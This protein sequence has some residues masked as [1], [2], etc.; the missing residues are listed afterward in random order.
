MWAESHQQRKLK[1][2]RP[3]SV[4]CTSP[5]YGLLEKENLAKEV[6]KLK[7]EKAKLLKQVSKQAN[8][9]DKLPLTHLQ[10]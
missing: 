8:Q 2:V 7:R 6:E 4:V 10:D 5:I 9:G 1:L 3:A